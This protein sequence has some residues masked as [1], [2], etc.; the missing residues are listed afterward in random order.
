MYSVSEDVSMDAVKDE[1]V[2]KSK[3]SLKNVVNYVDKKHAS[4]DFI[5]SQYSAVVDFNPINV[6][7]TLITIGAWYDNETAYACRVLDLTKHIM[8]IDE[9]AKK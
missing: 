8:T 6:K 4:S 5:G 3:C 7:D 2:N 1:I 9:L